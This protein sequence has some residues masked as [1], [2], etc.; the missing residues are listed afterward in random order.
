MRNILRP[1][2]VFFASSTLSLGILL[3]VDT[4]G[5]LPPVQT[6]SAS[7]GTHPLARLPIVDETI[8]RVSMEYVEPG[9]VDPERMFVAALEAVER[10]VPEVVFRRGPDTVD[11]RVGAH[12]VTL[13]VP[14]V[15]DLMALKRQLRTVA[16]LLDDH[17]APD[18]VPRDDPTLDPLEV[19]EYAMGNGL[20]STLD[21]HSALVPPPVSRE[22]DAENS[23]RFGGLGI[24]VRMDDDRLVITDV[25]DGTPADRSGLGA[26]DQIR[27]IDGQSTINLDLDEATSL[28]R[29]EPDE[30]VT[31]E[32]V[33]AD[34]RAVE[35]VVVVRADIKLNPVEGYA[36]P[37]GL[38]YVRIPSFHH[39]AH[40]DMMAALRRLGRDAGADGLQG[41]VLD[42]RGNPGGYLSQAIDV[43]NAF[44]EEGRE[45][46]T[47]RA[48]SPQHVAD[49]RARAGG[50]EDP[51]PI[52]VLV[53]A[54]S[55]SASEIVAGAL[56]NNERAVIVGTRTFGKAS[57]QNLHP[58]R[59]SQ[60]GKLKVTVAHYLTPG[61]RSIQGVGIPAD[62]ELVP[63]RVGRLDDAQKTARAELFGAEWAEREAD[64]DTP[65]VGADVVLDPP[66]FRIPFRATWETDE[67]LERQPRPDED[68]PLAFAI[69][70]LAV[71]P[72]PRRGD[73]LAAAQD[74]VARHQASADAEI[75][76]AFADLGVDWSDGPRVPD[77]P[78]E[79]DVSVGDE[80]HLVPGTR[81]EVTVRVTNHGDAA[82]HRVVAVVTD[83]EALQR[84]EFPLGKVDAGATRTWTED[85]VLHEGW[86][87]EAG[88]AT[89]ELR[90]GDGT[91]LQVV[92]APV[93]VDPPGAPSLS[94]RW[95]LEDEDGSVDVGDVVRVRWTV[96]NRG[97][98]PAADVT[99]RLRNRSGRA[100]D[101]LTG[102]VRAGSMVQDGRAC[103]PE[104]GGWEAGR[105]LGGLD[106]DDPRVRDR[107]PPRWPE[108][109]RRLLAAG[110]TW[111]GWF[112]VRVQERLEA[113]Y[114]LDLSVEDAAG[115]WRAYAHDVAREHRVQ[116]Q[117]LRFGL[118]PT[119]SPGPELSAPTITLTEA[120][121]LVVV[122]G[123]VR[124]AGEV[125]DTDGLDHVIVWVDDDKVFF[126]GARP[127]E[128]L[129][130]VAYDAQ[131]SVGPG[132]H[133]V[134][135]LA[136]DAAGF[137][138]SS[139]RVVH[140]PET[141][142]QARAPARSSAAR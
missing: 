48:A 70:L 17:L 127:G 46:V 129:P 53:D 137:V 3:L 39:E 111:E 108:R 92:E 40:R 60:D 131:V 21:P 5:S 67:H 81:G 130:A 83:H 140:R 110:A 120:P 56:R 59:A 12:R 90:S 119:P 78:L 61:E 91:V 50:T 62:V 55:A 52:A 47:T 26:G 103:R 136:R 84:Y 95:V 104:E 102:T 75:V 72:A 35:D 122:D 118:G 105:V 94:W 112:E 34:D 98:G 77:V 14:P 64:L 38:G 88:T 132:R 86:A 33:R 93:V 49:S 8:D 138:S 30:P 22:M 23:G 124:V 41:L 74:L 76:T 89:M 54:R 69:D 16:R 9:R 116:E 36:L 45:I 25:Q 139:T 6:A 57:V 66:V 42:L 29:G 115:T 63:A 19:V 27:R 106:A 43:A 73:M 18:D 96:T 58:L 20:L 114:R 87:P 141:S 51:Y 128:A 123:V 135:V 15:G 28:L 82:V 65:L 126:E 99:G 80:G 101:I 134:T 85:V 1:L 4:F 24:M 10:L 11:A 133:L 13:D 71:A 32:L 79:V 113:G 68:P 31:L 125:E 107:V 142:R 109:C 37:G 117:T 100:L 7:T 2:A 44:L 121:A 97:A